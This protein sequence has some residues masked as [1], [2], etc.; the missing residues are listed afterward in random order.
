MS[1]VCRSQDCTAGARC[2][3]AS[4]CDQQAGAHCVPP[5]AL[6]LAALAARFAVYDLYNAALRMLLNVR[7]RFT[8]LSK[9]PN[10]GSLRMLPLQL[11]VQARACMPVAGMHA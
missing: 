11:A 8:S 4:N 10:L 7:A 2:A 6:S 5:R 1:R 3:Y 9:P